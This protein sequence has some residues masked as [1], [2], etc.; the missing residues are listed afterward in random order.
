VNNNDTTDEEFAWFISQ[1]ADLS[2]LINNLREVSE[3]AR[4]DVEEWQ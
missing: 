1:Y 4:K 3:Q 2:V